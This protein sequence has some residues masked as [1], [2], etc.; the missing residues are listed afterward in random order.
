M[1]LWTEEE[2]ESGP[3]G[4]DGTLAKPNRNG[5][6]RSNLIALSSFKACAQLHIILHYRSGT[7]RAML[8]KP[9]KIS[10]KRNR[11]C[12]EGSADGQSFY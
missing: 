7:R 3:V 2:V 6:T 12:I 4:R 9:H 8:G 1:L 10:H 11:A 5:A